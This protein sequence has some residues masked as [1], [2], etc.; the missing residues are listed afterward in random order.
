[1][2]NLPPNP[3]NNIPGPPQANTH[4]GQQVFNHNQQFG[5]VPLG[6]LPPG[7]SALKQDANSNSPVHLPASTPQNS[8][9]QNVNNYHQSANS[10][11]AFNQP[12][13]L[14]PQQIGFQSSPNRPPSKPT[15]VAPSPNPIQV[16]SSNPSNVSNNA[17]SSPYPPNFNP[18]PRQINDNASPLIPSSQYNQPLMNGPQVGPPG[19]MPQTS[20]PYPVTSNTFSPPPMSM[21][22]P[23]SGTGFGPA[24]TSAPLQ[25]VPPGPNPVKPPVQQGILPPQP[26]I[27]YSGPPRSSPLN[28]PQPISGSTFN[29]PLVSS[30]TFSG[31]MGQRPL[32]VNGPSSLSGPPG[33]PHLSG[34]PMGGSG[35]PGPMPP[36]SGPPKMPP[37]SAAAIQSYPG[38]PKNGPGPGQPMPGPPGP[39]FMGSTPN[40]MSGP[41][42]LPS[43]PKSLPLGPPGQQ[44]GH[45]MGPPMNAQPGP[46]INAQPGPPSGPPMS[47]PPVSGKSNMQNRYP[48]MPQGN[49]PNHQPQMPPQPAMGNQ[50]P[51]QYPNQAL[52]Q[53]MGQLSVT[54]QGFDQLWGHQM[55]DLLQCRHIL[56]EY[57]EDPPEIRL[58]HQFADSAN[59]SPE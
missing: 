33:A 44:F 3:Y 18:P 37:T 42:S 11:P 22:P 21:R 58:G 38:P 5:Q 53:Q 40:A 57:P 47:G 39:G 20:S 48:Q 12:G 41:P 49:F 8:V 9:L 15:A 10:S 14:P 46:P 35:L 32:G 50:Y 19:P 30:S 1:M 36:M 59:C 7:Y 27:P 2:S 56:P 25:Q 4:S 52:A 24:I 16:P 31:P 26:N 23:I 13:M 54:K 17:N 6:Q 45:S 29:G 51:Q 55:I 28:P 34:P 43:G